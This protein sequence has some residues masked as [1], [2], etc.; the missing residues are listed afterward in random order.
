MKSIEFSTGRTLV[1]T[2]VLFD[3]PGLHFE[4]RAQILVLLNTESSAE[5]ERGQ[6]Y[7]GESSVVIVYLYV[8]G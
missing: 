5:G 2:S 3:G 8:G 7:N 6:R 1:H 4:K